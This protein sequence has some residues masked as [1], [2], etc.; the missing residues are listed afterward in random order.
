VTW[1]D[2][3]GLPYKPVHGKGGEFLWYLV[4]MQN[5]SWMRPDASFWMTFTFFDTEK[6]S[7][8]DAGQD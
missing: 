8:I 2:A 6:L 5:G 1:L 4:K 7:E 3:S